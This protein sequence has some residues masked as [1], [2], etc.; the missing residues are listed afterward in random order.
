MGK[1]TPKIDGQKL[2]AILGK[3]IRFFRQQR[4]LSQASLAEKAGIS[5]TFLSNIERGIKYPTS[6]TLSAIS[7]SL[8][9][10][11][12]ELFRHDHSPA[13]YRTLFERFKI[14]ITKNIIKTLETVY[15]AYEK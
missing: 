8:E 12:Y 3:G 10:E 1:I 6:E 5:I 4:Q 15:K 9:V 14:D 13:E 11:V 2:R 7:N